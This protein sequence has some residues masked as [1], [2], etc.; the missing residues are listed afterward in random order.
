MNNRFLLVGLLSIAAVGGLV[1][2]LYL[3]R[4]RP[5]KMGSDTIRF[6]CAAGIRKPVK[7]VME[8]YEKR[9]GVQFETVFDGSGKLLSAI[10]ADGGRGDAYLAAD[11]SY[12]KEARQFDLNDEVF[13]IARQR[14]CIAV[15]ASNDSIQSIDDLLKTDVKISLANPEVA[16]ISRVARRMLKE[17][18]VDGR[19]F[20]DVIYDKATV[21]RSTVNEVANDVK[22]G[23]TDAGV[24]W[25]ATARQYGELKIV[26]ASEFETSSQQIVATVLRSSKQPTRIL[27]FLRFMTSKEQGMPVFEKHGYEVLP[28]DAWSENPEIT[29]YTGGLMHPAIQDSIAEFEKR[30]GARVAQVP[31]GCGILVAQIRSGQHP[32]LY[33]A[34]DTTFMSRVQNIFPKWQDLSQTEMVVVTTKKR[35]VEVS[36]IDD[37]VRKDLKVGLCDPEHSALGDLTKRLLQ[38]RGIYSQVERNVINRTSTADKLVEAVVLGNLDAAVVYLANTTRQK[39]KLNIYRIDSERAL[40]VQPIGVAN[41]SRY[42]NLTERLVK[43][44]RSADSRQRFESLG[45][46]WLGE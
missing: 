34:C 17:K 24:V 33:F 29:L 46:V 31:S 45:F 14:P 6:Y 37:L 8:A 16:A 2:S 7:E 41:D 32:D 38:Q 5:T 19:A 28:G 30:E 18:T 11:S 27:H 12:M 42:P 22:S 26:A 44:L 35:N 4:E 9:Y 3:G 39:D 1:A 21:Q 20:W 23:A 25:D 43:K 36:N 10:R 13:S 15:A 40:A